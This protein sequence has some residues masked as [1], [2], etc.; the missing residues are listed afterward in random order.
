MFISVYIYCYLIILYIYIFQTHPNDCCRV[1]SR[2]MELQA[3]Q[4]AN[5]EYFRTR[6]AASGCWK[7]N[8]IH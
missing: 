3:V 8:R 5:A 6:Q 7:S 2:T 1:L 4:A